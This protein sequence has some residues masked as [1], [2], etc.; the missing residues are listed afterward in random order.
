MTIAKKR[1]TRTVDITNLSKR[2]GGENEP[3][4]MS[5]YAAV[6]NSRTSI[7][8]FFDEIIDPGAFSRTISENGDIRALYNHDWD[9]VLG[10]T[11][12]GTLNLSEDNRGLKFELELPDTSVARDLAVSMDR[13]D[14][15][16][17]SFGFF[18]NEETWDYDAEPV[19]RTI[20]EVE[21]FE[22][23][24]VSLP[25]Y[26]DTEVELVRSKEVD[27]TVEK[28]IKLLNKIKGVLD[29]E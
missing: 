18:I 6:F 9:N 22:V 3:L 15:N 11:K 23:S 19:L 17:C 29:N 12:S 14:I 4:K 2:D 26:D 24:I 21:L 20:H 1:E 27:E 28:R 8:D 25:A 16:Q 10:R 7:G 13:G 5:G